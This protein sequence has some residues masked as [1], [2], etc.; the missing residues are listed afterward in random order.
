MTRSLLP[1]PRPAGLYLWGS[2]LILLLAALL[3]FYR[4]EYQSYWHDEGNSLHLAG[5]SAALIIQSAAA[6]IHPPAYYLA[7]KLWRLGLGE[8]EFALRGLSALAGVVLVALLYRLGRDFFGPGA[9]LAAAAL[10]ALNP[11]LI[12]YSQEARMYALAATL[13]AASFGLLARWLG[14]LW[15]PAASTGGSLERRLNMP[16]ANFRKVLAERGFWLDGLG[17]ML[18][19]AWG[20]YTHYA[21]G[22][23]I[24]AQN[25]IVGVWHLAALATRRP[26]A[27]TRLGAWLG[28]QAIT[29]IVYL[30]WLP[31]AYHQLTHWPSTRVYQPFLSAL[32]DVTCY[33]AFGRTLPPAGLG[34]VL[35]LMALTLVWGASRRRE[36]AVALLWLVVPAGLTLGFG[37]FSEAFSK[38]LLVAVPPLCLLLGQGLAASVGRLT[39]AVPF[40]RPRR[41]ESDGQPHSKPAARAFGFSWRRFLIEAKSLLG[42]ILGTCFLVSFGSATYA[43]LQNL[44][45][46]PAYFRDDYR[47]IARY[48]EGMARPGDAIILI[49]PNQIEAFGYYHRSGAEVFP[50]PHARP[51]DEAETTAALEDLT[52]RHTRLFV[53]YYADE[54]ADPA[55][56]VEGWLNAHTFKAS[57]TW[58]GQVRLALYAVSTPAAQMTVP[59]GARWGQHI[60]LAGYTLQAESLAPGDILQIT[61]FWQTDAP[62]GVRYKVF[63]H[64]YADPAQPPPAQQDGEPGGGRRP[65][66]AWAAGQRYADNHGVLIPADLPPGRYTLAIGLYN[67]FDQTRLDVTQAGQTLGDRL[68][69]GTITIK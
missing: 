45:F 21:F 33:L 58:Y 11:F 6:D 44:Y 60:S 43:S 42:I 19:S 36:F 40:G 37:L 14:R 23:I 28:L 56:F 57:D 59:S 31:V 48:V 41:I 51:L 9:A 64:L 8:T 29:L 30:P 26:A 67:L 10:G 39:H 24:L 35:A 17:Y 12:Y 18:V 20:L 53:L 3:R 15:G 47:G 5:E 46:N 25:V 68:E 49:A 16:R 61:L 63:V 66:T 69:L 34:T 62:L 2:V 7:L 27:S 32:A 38:F 65:T 1:R 13:G 4:I 54:Q 55:H 52:A 50:L 22:F